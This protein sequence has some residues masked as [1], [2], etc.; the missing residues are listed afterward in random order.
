[1]KVNV[2]RANEKRIMKCKKH[3]QCY[4]DMIEKRKLGAEK[5]NKNYTT[6]KRRKAGVKAWANRKKS[7]PNI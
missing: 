2:L 7:T 5:T 6:E 4:I 1:M 3:C